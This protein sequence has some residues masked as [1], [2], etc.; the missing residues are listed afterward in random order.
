M[1]NDER[2]TFLG[3]GENSDALWSPVPGRS[4]KELGR[5]LQHEGEID[6]KA[7]SSI[8]DAALRIL[9]QAAPP[10]GKR[11]R[12]TGLV[13]GYVQSGK[14]MSMTTVSALARDNGFRI[15]IVFAGVTSILLSQTRARFQ[16]H[17][18][19]AGQYP[20]QWHILDYEKPAHLRTKAHELQNL[21]ATWR[22]D[23]ISDDRKPALL[24]TV[25]KNSRHLNALAQLLNSTD[26]VDLPVLIID[27]E[28]DQAGLNTTPT[29]AQA[30]STH[31][32]IAAVRKQ[33]PH[34]TYLQYTATPQAPLLISLIDMLSPEFAEVLEAG[35]GY[36][37]GDAFFR[38]GQGIVAALPEDELFKPGEP[39]ADP[40]AGLIRALQQF[41]VAAGAFGVERLH[42]ERKSS[43]PW[44]M[45][46]HPSQRQSDHGAYLRW[47]Q[48]IQ[49]QWRKDLGLPESDPDRATLVQEFREAYDEL[50]LTDNSLPPFDEVL[51]ELPGLIAVETVITELNSEHGNEVPWG[52]AFAHVLV[53]GEKLNRG[54][55]VKGLVT[56]YM[57]RG[58]GGWNA[59]TIQQRARF[60]GYKAAYL[61]RCRVHLHPQVRTAY[62]DYVEHEDHVRRK[63]VEFRGRPLVEWK[64]AFFLDGAMRPTRAN[65]LS[66]PYYKVR[67]RQQWFIQLSPHDDAIRA[68][69][70]QVVDTLLVDVQLAP[71]WDDGR[72]LSG[73][74]PVAELLG[75]L[76]VPFAVVGNHDIRWMYAVRV[77]LD[78]IHQDAPTAMARIIL[79]DGGREDESARTRRRSAESGLVKQIPQGADAPSGYPGDREILDLSL[80]TVQIHRLRVVEDGVAYDNV[81]A[82]SVRIPEALSSVLVQPGQS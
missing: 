19:P 52:N 54:F 58:A 21:V 23:D 13:V 78:T 2:V 33:L 82:L 35:D 27:D 45:L 4:I 34:H 47:I 80:V 53:G 28:A 46:V 36:T 59:D 50:G 32:H 63:L 72:H 24:L 20:K 5:T 67:Q 73:V 77:W 71:Y 76:M 48:Q 16:Q 8:T 57:P 25:M 51:N 40:P 66:D 1:S 41:F 26:L 22:N 79:M 49:K 75:R 56:T 74:I 39:P 37:G 10:K 65:V 6:S 12:R 64:R 62:R 81:F 38:T 14:T 30:S 44:S 11:A 61:Q 60:F 69:N 70:K 9:S 7:F 55:T 42:G 29:K 3:G 18:Q 15:V 17:L 31:R 43:G 68:A